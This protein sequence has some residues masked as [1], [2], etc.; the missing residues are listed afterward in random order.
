MHESDWRGW[1]R[2]YLRELEAQIAALRNL[3]ARVAGLKGSGSDT[4]RGCA[5]VGRVRPR[6]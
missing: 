4:R 1:V 3:E 5:S 2:Q 6:E